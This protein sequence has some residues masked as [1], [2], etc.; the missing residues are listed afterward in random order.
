VSPRSVVQK[1]RLTGQARWGR[2]KGGDASRAKKP[3]STETS[4]GGGADKGGGRLVVQKKPTL[5]EKQLGGGER[6]GVADDLVAA[7]HAPPRQASVGGGPGQWSGEA[8]GVNRLRK[9]AKST[10]HNWFLAA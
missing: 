3:R 2:D 4:S 8:A 9:H 6:K 10:H 5:H 7:A 1:P